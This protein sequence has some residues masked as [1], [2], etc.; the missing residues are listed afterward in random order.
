MPKGW[1]KKKE[2]FEDCFYLAKNRMFQHKDNENVRE[3]SM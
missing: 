3:V 1:V 2:K